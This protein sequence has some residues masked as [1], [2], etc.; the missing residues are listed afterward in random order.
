MHPTITLFGI[1]CPLYSCVFLLGFILAVFFGRSVAEKREIAKEDVLYCSI[2][3][4][5]GIIVGSKL[6]YL[7][8]R[9]P[10]FIA[11]F[12]VFIKAFNRNS[13]S[14]LAIAGGYLLGG[15]V[16]YGGMIGAIILAIVYCRKYS[17]DVVA[18]TELISVF[19]PFIHSFGRL[20]CFFAGCCYGV[21]YYGWGCLQFPYNEFIPELSQVPRFP[22][23]LLEA[24]VNFI[25]FLL[26]LYLYMRITWAKTRILGIYICYYVV[27]RFIMEF[28]RGDDI[29]GKVGFLTTS[30]LISILLL[31]IGISII[32]R[33]WLQKTQ[34]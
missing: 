34:M 6:L 19:I 23:Q 5:I 30:Q 20:G 24:I 10:H 28:F 18:M 27:F 25:V 22:T 11:S 7:I 17:V 2:Y 13:Q 16:F 26:L 15:N 14:A 3:A 9:L 31:P 8:T 29:R 21:E 1:E 32:Y 4:A 12:E 33:N